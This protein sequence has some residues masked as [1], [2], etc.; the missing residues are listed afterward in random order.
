MY[1]HE[2]APTDGAYRHGRTTRI[3]ELNL[4]GNPSGTYYYLEGLFAYMKQ[5]GFE[6]NDRE[7][8]LGWLTT[9]SGIFIVAIVSTPVT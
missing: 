6:N 2:S 8:C 3:L 7:V 9:Q 5:N 1:I 4:Y